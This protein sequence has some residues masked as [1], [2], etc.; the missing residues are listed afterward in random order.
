M[1]ML[2]N[3]N[4]EHDNLACFIHKKWQNQYIM[5]ITIIKQVDVKKTLFLSFFTGAFIL[6]HLLRC[7][8]LEP[9]AQCDH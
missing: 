4:V 8:T 3:I 1:L 9:L 2:Y 5:L 6:T 7:K